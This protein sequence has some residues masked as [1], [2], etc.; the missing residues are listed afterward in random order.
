MKTRR[1]AS[2]AVGLALPLT[3]V[4]TATADIGDEVREAVPNGAEI[5]EQIDIPSDF[6]GDSEDDVSFDPP[7]S[8]DFSDIDDSVREEFGGIDDVVRDRVLG[9]E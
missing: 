6:G 5:R 1:L 3:L 2:L 8:G 7:R 4:G 9:G